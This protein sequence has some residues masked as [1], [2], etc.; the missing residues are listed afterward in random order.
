MRTWITRFVRRCVSEASPLFLLMKPLIPSGS[1]T[2][3]AVCSLA[4]AIAPVQ[5][6]EAARK[7]YDIA[8]GDAVSTLAEAFRG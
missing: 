4:C 6:G 8:A 7:S 3:F 5:A 2:A 1:A